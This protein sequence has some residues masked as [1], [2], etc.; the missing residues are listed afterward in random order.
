MNEEKPDDLV[1]RFVLR[2]LARAPTRERSEARL[3]LARPTLAPDPRGRGVE[4]PRGQAGPS[5]PLGAP[6]RWS[7]RLALVVALLLATSLGASA[8]TT[9]PARTIPLTVGPYQFE[10]N[11][12]SWPPH[13]DQE[14]EISLAPSGA[15]ALPRSAYRL[16]L[17]VVPGPGVD[18]TALTVAVG[19]DPDDPR[20][21]VARPRI[22]VAGR[23]TLR[24]A[25]AGPRGAASEEIP[26]DVAAPP[27]IPL[28]LGWLIGLS[29]L[30][31]L[32]VFGVSEAR[33]LRRVG[34]QSVET[35]PSGRRPASI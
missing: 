17:T 32:A 24:L 21:F 27:A 16:A 11:A 34:K 26:W 25:V 19:P 14:V 15:D 6:S 30:I 8:H 29:P 20:G 33:W 1:V 12:Y 31:G 13:T 5:A 22:P 7:L 9:G 3:A 2:R 10:L 23:W 18:A 28:W 35:R 4:R